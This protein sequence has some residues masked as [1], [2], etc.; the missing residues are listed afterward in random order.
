MNPFFQIAEQI[1]VNQL[2][3]QFQKTMF[4]FRQF[5]FGFSIKTMF[6][7]NIRKVQTSRTVIC[8]SETPYTVS[9]QIADG[10]GPHTFS[11][12]SAK[13]ETELQANIVHDSLLMVIEEFEQFKNQKQAA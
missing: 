12:Y 1:A 4:D 8:D 9:F 3:Q 7:S 11:T 6:I 13:F 10:I 2:R 5:G